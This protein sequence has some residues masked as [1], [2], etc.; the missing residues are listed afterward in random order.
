MASIAKQLAG[1]LYGASTIGRA[2]WRTLVQW[3]DGEMALRARHG[4]IRRGRLGVGRGAKH[5]EHVQL[6]L[7][8]D[9]YSLADTRG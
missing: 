6:E 2:G 3:E 9:T 7:R 5:I 1:A 8:P 4:C